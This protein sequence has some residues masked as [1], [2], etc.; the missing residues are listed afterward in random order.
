MRVKI[1]HLDD[2]V[3]TVV[4]GQADVGHDGRQA[5]EEVQEAIHELF[6]RIR[7]IKQKAEHSEHMVCVCLPVCLS[8]S[9]LYCTVKSYLLSSVSVSA[10]QED[11]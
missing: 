7:N 2:E 5:L 1:Q 8:V 3:R 9:P 11:H 10:G 6:G 4:R